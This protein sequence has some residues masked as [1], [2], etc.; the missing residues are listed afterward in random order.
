MQWAWMDAVGGMDAVGM[1]A[2]GMGAVG[3]GQCRQHAGT[4][5]RTLVTSTWAVRASPAAG[6]R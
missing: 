4:G 6:R 3:I 5:A 1:G 2:V